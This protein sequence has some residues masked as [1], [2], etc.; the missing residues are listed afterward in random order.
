MYA[1]DIANQAFQNA[2]ISEYTS[3]GGKDAAG[4]WLHNNVF[5]YYYPKT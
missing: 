1:C 5:Q 2:C 3:N 4:F